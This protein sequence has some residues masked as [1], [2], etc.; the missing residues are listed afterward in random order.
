MQNSGKFP[1][2]LVWLMAP[3]FAMNVVL[4]G[5]CVIMPI[6]VGPG[7]AFSALQIKII[8]IASY[9]LKAIS[10]LI[11]QK[12]A[13]VGFILLLIGCLLSTY[14]AWPFFWGNLITKMLL[15]DLSILLLL[16][17]IIIS[18]KQKLRQK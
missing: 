8:Y 12:N 16:A 18:R 4:S 17:Y 7:L 9:I 6:V 2:G 15:L 14:L 5:F 1:S 11:L 10:V 3:Y 13:A